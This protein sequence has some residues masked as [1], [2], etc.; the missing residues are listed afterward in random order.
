MAMTDTGARRINCG[1]EYVRRGILQSESEG[2]KQNRSWHPSGLQK[3][4]NEKCKEE[5]EKIRKSVPSRSK[6][7]SSILSP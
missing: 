3:Q 7:L 2:K 6:T 5:E 4:T 1:P